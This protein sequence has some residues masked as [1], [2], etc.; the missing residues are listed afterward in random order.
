MPSR[1]FRRVKIAPGVRVNFSKSLPSMS[2]GVRGAHVTV[3]HKR[4]RATVGI[5][6]TGLFYTKYSHQHARAA[7][8]KGGPARS[9]RSSGAPQKTTIGEVFRKPPGAKIGYGILLTVLVVTSP[10]GI[11]LLLTGIFQWFLSKRWHA[12]SLVAKAAKS[13]D[14]E[15]A[16]ALLD[17]AELTLPGDPEVLA[18]LAGWNA[19]QHNFEEAAALY[20]LYLQRS[21]NDGTA[22]AHYARCL[23]LSG[24]SDAAIEQFVLVRALPL[25]DESQASITTFLA[26]AHLMKGDAGQ[27]LA[28]LKEAPL[29][30]HSLGIGLQQCLQYRAV[31]FYFTGDTKRAISD[32]DRLYAVNPAYKDVLEDKATM[33]A[34]TFVLDAPNGPIT[35]ETLKGTP[36]GVRSA[37]DVA[38]SS[39]NA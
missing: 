20:A 17:Q 23:L 18:P 13:S 22:R 9:V 36:T 32:M 12:R 25:D 3:G 11:P 5:P 38:G 35:R 24:D 7:T 33:A 28:L 31:A 21:P 19:D 8:R 1:F 30:R 37:P 2:V 10:V 16:K 27:A 26:I 29:Q 15:E 34:G 14:P 6:G 4:R 39:A